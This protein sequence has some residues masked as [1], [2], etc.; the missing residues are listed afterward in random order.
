M[1]KFFT[2]C[3]AALVVMSASALDLSKLQK[4]SAKNLEVMKFER[5]TTTPIRKAPA[6][7][8]TAKAPFAERYTA[9]GFR[10]D[11]NASEES[12]P[13]VETTPWEVY[14]ATYEDEGETI[15]GICNIIPN[16]DMWKED[17]IL[18]YIYDEE[19]GQVIV[20]CTPLQFYDEETIIYIM[21]IYDFGQGGSGDICFTLD[22]DGNLARPADVLGHAVAWT[23]AYFNP[24]TYEPTDILGYFGVY[25]AMKYSIGSTALDKV[26][27]D[28]KVTKTIKN[29]QIVINK[30][31]QSYNILG[32][33]L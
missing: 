12:D 20:P 3:A 31:G 10:Y 21:D 14:P 16:E 22:K 9:N 33:K 24:E 29:G 8:K 19:K 4:F 1:K 13:W 5:S 27:A 28:A 32:V 18:D 15:H 26:A 2:L 30:N 11:F 6:A 25:A 17:P 7:L 23:V